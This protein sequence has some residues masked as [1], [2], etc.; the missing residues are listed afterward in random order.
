MIKYLNELVPR[1]IKATEITE[2]VE[3]ARIAGPFSCRG[4]ERG[5]EEDLAE[6]LLM[7]FKQ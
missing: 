3:T 1:K 4:G 6:V 7:I 5:S 2:I